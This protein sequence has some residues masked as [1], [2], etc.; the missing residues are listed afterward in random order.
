MIIEC[1]GCFRPKIEEEYQPEKTDKKLE[2][3]EKKSTSDSLNGTGEVHA[4]K[5]KSNKLDKLNDKLDKSNPLQSIDKE[6]FLKNSKHEKSESQNEDESLKFANNSTEVNDFAVIKGKS[7]CIN[8]SNNGELS[9][10]SLLYNWDIKFIKFHMTDIRLSNTMVI[11][12]VAQ[13]FNT[14]RLV[15]KDICVKIADNEVHKS[16]IDIFY[17]SSLQI[18]SY[19]TGDVYMET[20]SKEDAD[21]I[22]IFNLNDKII[23]KKLIV[24]NKIKMFELQDKFMSFDEILKGKS[25]LH[26]S[27]NDLEKLM[28]VFSKKHPIVIVN[29]SC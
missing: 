22:Y 15:S 19:V 14:M 17:D 5:P 24:N 7:M 4:I 28:N 12:G 18:K 21:V 16:Y 20:D 3:I 9:S 8:G 13:R 25:N 26:G 29:C 27:I 1:C 6:E 2:L 11:E 10:C 23:I